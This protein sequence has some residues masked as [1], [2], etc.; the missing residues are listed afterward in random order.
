MATR[1]RRL[2]V[3]AALA[4][5]L[6][7]GCLHDVHRIGPIA[8]AP[9][10]RPAEVRVLVLGDFGADTLTQRLVAHAI[11]A[12]ARARPFDLAVELGDNNYYCG[13]DPAG[14]AAAGCRFDRNGA[15]VVPGYLPPADGRFRAA[16]D[17]LAGLRARGGG[18]LP[19][20]LAL[21]NHDIGWGEGSCAV[22]GVPV[23][24]AARRRACL[25]VAHRGPAWIM[26][27]RHYVVDR[28]PIR[29]VVVDTNVVVADYGGFTLD[30]EVAFVRDA[31][32]GC[33]GARFCFL[34]G[35]HPPAAVHGY[36]RAG[37]SPYG[38]R[39]ARLVA[40]AEGRAAAFLA[41]HVHDLEHLAL[42]PLDVFV[43]GSTAQGGFQRLRWRVPATARALFA[44]SAWGFAILE[45]DRAGW[46][47]R[48][49][50]WRGEALHCCEA[51]AGGPCVPVDC[52]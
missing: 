36:G 1:L 35:H 22:P 4:A 46:R 9:P 26:P 19:V 12:E 33:G 14:P 29:I 16:E 37:P 2:A 31:T 15:T 8:P 11:R 18:P 39:M 44:T 41:G 28:G 3:R 6:M 45:A 51:A 34:A 52:R 13:P 27:A 49:Q 48:F 38:V 40:A 20:Y 47:V 25:E 24:E 23:N 10:A 21:G 32:K 30:Q 17:P 5:A 7:G 42:G 43:S 50:D